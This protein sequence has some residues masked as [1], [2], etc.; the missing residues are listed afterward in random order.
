MSRRKSAIMVK[1][2]IA[3]ARERTIASREWRDDGRLRRHPKDPLT[4]EDERLRSRKGKV[5]VS[6]FTRYRH[7]LFIRSRMDAA[8]LAA[9]EE[10]F[11]LDALRPR[12]EWYVGTYQNHDD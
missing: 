4:V 1:Q 3:D 5:Y 7:E 2:E 12:G 9:R 6:P 11:P 10:L 8:A